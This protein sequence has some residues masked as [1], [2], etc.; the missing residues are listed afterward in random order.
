MVKCVF[1]HLGHLVERNLSE[2]SIQFWTFEVIDSITSPGI[3]ASESKEFILWSLKIFKIFLIKL[4]N[5]FELYVIILLGFVIKKF[6]TLEERMVF[7]K[8]DHSFFFPFL[9]F[10]I[11]L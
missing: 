4:L 10:F 7:A 5:L 6:I 9:S 2:G 11:L 3:K 1:P 8:T